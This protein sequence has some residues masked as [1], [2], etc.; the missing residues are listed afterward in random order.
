MHYN[1]MI[2]YL[3]QIVSVPGY[4]PVFFVIAKNLGLCYVLSINERLFR[5]LIVLLL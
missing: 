4:C 1:N 2:W 5:V 3:Q